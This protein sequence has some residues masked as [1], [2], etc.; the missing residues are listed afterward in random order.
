MK[1][2]L[3]IA[4]IAAFA[5]A[6]CATQP[7]PDLSA[8]SVSTV[9]SAALLEDVR[10]ARAYASLASVRNATATLLERRLIKLEDAERVQQVANQVR[11]GLDLARSALG[12]GREGN[13]QMLLAQALQLLATLET[14]V[15]EKSR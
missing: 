13:Y 8:S 11:A 4:A 3:I 5:A 14:Y 10:V 2:Y 9:Q 12:A 7:A 1:C 6:G 15:Q